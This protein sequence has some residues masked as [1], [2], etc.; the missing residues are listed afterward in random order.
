M[1]SK[2][3]GDPPHDDDPHGAL[4]TSHSANQI[5]SLPASKGPIIAH[6]IIQKLFNVN[7]R[8]GND[9]YRL[10]SQQ[11]TPNKGVEL[12]GASRPRTPARGG[13]RPW[14]TVGAFWSI[15]YNF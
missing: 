15:F 5:I 11:W 8:Y 9:D 7:V 12:P 1:G 2:T 4:I 10:L 6:G 3:M 14:G 13:M